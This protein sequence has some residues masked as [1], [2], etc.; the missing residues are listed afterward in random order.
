MSSI[1]KIH[2]LIIKTIS[3][4][5]GGLGEAASTVD[6]TLDTPLI[7]GEHF[8]SFALVSL[9]IALDAEIEKEFSISLDLTTNFLAE[10]DGKKNVE[11]VCEAILSLLE[12]TVQR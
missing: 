4:F 7:G 2:E 8:D 1:Q 10:A 12:N 5:D 11:E 9:F 6:L 3:E